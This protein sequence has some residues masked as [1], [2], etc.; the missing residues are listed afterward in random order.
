MS[1][2]GP[3]FEPRDTVAYTGPVAV[4]L[5]LFPL[6]TVLFPHMP[7]GVHVFEPRYRQMLAD[8]AEAQTGF[9]IV[10][11]AAGAE[12]GGPARPHPVGTLAQV[13]SDD[14]LDD[15]RHD[16][17]VRGTTRFAIQALRLDRPYLVAEVR[18]LTEEPGADADRLSA[19]AGQVTTAFI[20]YVN[21][22][23]SLAGSDE[24]QIEVPDDPEKL[25]YLVSATL[26]IDTAHRQA[27][28][29]VETTAERLRECLRLLRREVVFLDQMLTRRHPG[30]GLVSPN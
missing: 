8:C 22:L 30:L 4:D 1:L 11:I 20:R 13:V 17:L 14:R 10:A 12:V 19:L 5:P 28:L 6:G 7:L 23:R 21:G 25:A 24:D 16:L 18:W 27:L 3:G 15:G 29:Q 9:G 2:A 26:Q